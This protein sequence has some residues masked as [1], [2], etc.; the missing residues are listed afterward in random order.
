M[1]KTLLSAGII[2]DYEFMS[3]DDYEIYLYQLDHRQVVYKVIETFERSDG[4]VIVRI[5]QQYNN[6]DLIEL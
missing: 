6:V 3:F 1:I 2:R 5:L 4:T